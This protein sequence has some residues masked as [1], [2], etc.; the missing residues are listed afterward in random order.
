[1]P[2]QQHYMSLFKSFVLFSLIVAIDLHAQQLVSLDQP[3]LEQSKTSATTAIQFVRQRTEHLRL[4][5]AESFIREVPLTDRHFVRAYNIGYDKGFVLVANK[6]SD[7]PVVIGYSDEGKIEP[8]DM[9]SQFLEWV[10]SYEAALNGCKTS[11]LSRAVADRQAVATHPVVLPLLTVQWNQTDPYNLYCPDGCPTGC[12]AT[13]MA[14]VMAYH[15]WPEK[16]DWNRMN[17]AYVGKGYETTEASEPVARLMYDCGKAVQMKY[18]PMASNASPSLVPLALINEFGYDSRARLVDRNTYSYEGWDAL[19]CHELQEGRPVIYGG[20]SPYNIGHEFVVDGVN[21]DGYYHVNWGWGGLCNGYFMLLDMTP[22]ASGAGGTAGYDG[23]N[24][25]VQAIIGIQPPKVSGEP[26]PP[27]TAKMTVSSMGLYSADEY[28]RNPTTRFFNNVELTFMVANLTPLS[29]ETELSFLMLDDHD[30]IVGGI[31]SG[32]P[33]FQTSRAECSSG[34][35][36]GRNTYIKVTFGRNLTD[37]HYRIVAAYRLEPD[38]A[39]LLDEGS[40][41]HYLEAIVTGSKMKLIAH[42]VADLHVREVEYIG[43]RSKG[44]LQ[45]VRV[46]IENRGEDFTDNLYL[47]VNGEYASGTGTLISSGRTTDVHFHYVPQSAGNDQLS[48]SRSSSG[49]HPFYSGSFAIAD[50]QNSKMPLLEISELVIDN[51]D[52]DDHLYG[53]SLN[54]SFMVTDTTNIDYTGKLRPVV[55]KFVETVGIGVN[56]EEQYCTIP[57]GKS[58]RYSIHLKDLLEYGTT[59][60]IGIDYYLGS[61]AVRGNVSAPFVSTAGVSEWTADG[62]YSC[63]PMTANLTVGADV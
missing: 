58:M 15:R 44:D 29:F 37:G 21:E 36:F 33:I 12:V 52:D 57:A 23:Y 10:S 4:S 17:V 30:A 32:M 35:I 13:A 14:Q 34:S 38:G 2:S 20:T 47:F 22:T 27:A 9:P 55:Y 18:D 63:G 40:D 28:E 43:N 62:S 42:P 11:S 26:L 50:G 49:S 1:M 41:R 53:N 54:V 24:M 6:S 59:Y 60:A 61:N 51:L 45:D 19:M 7:T 25:D 39:W 16:Y 3:R 48:I 31:I 8:E 46:T 56:C 5:A